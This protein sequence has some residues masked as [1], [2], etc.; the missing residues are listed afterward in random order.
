MERS[1]SVINKISKAWAAYLFVLPMLIGLIVFNLKPLI[2]AVRLSFFKAGIKT[3]IFI[4]LK[5]YIEMFKDP[6]F[7]IVMKNTL[8]Y[9]FAMVPLII[10]IP[11][12]IALIVSKLK[13]GGQTFFRMAFYLPVV[14]A[15]V[16]MSLVWLWIFHPVFGLANYALSLFGIDPVMWLAQPFTARLAVCIVQIGWSIGIPLILYLSALAAVPKRIYEA[17]SIDGANPFQQFTKITI[18]LIMPTTV[19]VLIIASV[20]RFQTFSAIFLLTAGGPANSTI[21]I[22]YRIYQLGFGFFRFGEASTYGMILLA[23][24]FTVAFVQFRWLSKKLEF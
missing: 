6:I 13:S 22:C 11:L 9:V 5:N 20:G 14:S 15:G 19:Y 8:F 24:C 16:V 17:A 23:I 3:E 21:S 2:D 7:W 12:L 1:E 4:G 18:P 10:F